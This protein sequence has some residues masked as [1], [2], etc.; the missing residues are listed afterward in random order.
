MDY[1]SKKITP[2]ERAYLLNTF[3]DFRNNHIPLSVPIGI[4]KS[5]LIRFQE[6]YLLAKYRVKFSFDV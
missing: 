3:E 4:I 5:W 6:H 1:V 2:E